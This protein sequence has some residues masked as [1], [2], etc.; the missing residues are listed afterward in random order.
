M[1]KQAH[2]NTTTNERYFTILV[3]RKPS[4]IIIKGYIYLK[5]INLNFFFILRGE[6]FSNSQ[7]EICHWL[8]SVN[9]YCQKGY[10]YGKG[11]F[12][13]ER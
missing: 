9:F 11:S 3:W 13:S 4:S 1:H 7:K 10:C 12:I 8:L 5:N 2:D 6:K